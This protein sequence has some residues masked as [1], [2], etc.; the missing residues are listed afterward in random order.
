MWTGAAGPANGRLG[1]DFTRAF[2][3]DIRPGE[4]KSQRKRPDGA[5]RFG[6]ATIGRTLRANEPYDRL[7]LPLRLPRRNEDN[8]R[9]TAPSGRLPPVML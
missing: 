6:A 4:S 3:Y 1:R 8:Q 2:K 5:T 9:Q 7:T